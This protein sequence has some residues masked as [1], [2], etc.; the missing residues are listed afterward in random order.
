MMSYHGEAV[1]FNQRAFE[2]K[3]SLANSWAR[4]RRAICNFNSPSVC[5]IL[6][7][8]RPR[9]EDW[10]AAGREGLMRCN[11]DP[12]WSAEQVLCSRGKTRALVLVKEA[13]IIVVRELD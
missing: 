1:C 2:N 3:S 7:A 4:V 5:E 9:S 12:H 6:R 13:M 8:A 10:F 11:R